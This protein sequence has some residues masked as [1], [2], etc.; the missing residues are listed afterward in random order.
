MFLGRDGHFSSL[1]SLTIYK[2]VSRIWAVITKSSMNVSFGGSPDYIKMPG[3]WN[4]II[5]QDKRKYI[6]VKNNL[7]NNSIC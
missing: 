4:S 7:D 3:K 2:K 1:K 6:S 5:I